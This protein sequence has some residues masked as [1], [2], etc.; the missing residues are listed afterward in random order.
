MP[1][2]VLT[3]LVAASL[4]GAATCESPAE[5][6]AWAR[7][8]IYPGASDAQLK[9]VRTWVQAAV[10]S[11]DDNGDLWYLRS[12]LAKKLDGKVDTFAEE[13]L[14]DHPSELQANGWNPFDPAQAPAKPRTSPYV[15]NKWA[16]VVG[17][18]KFQDNSVPTLSHSVNDAKR[19]AEA[20]SGP[21]GR[22]DPAHVKVLTDEAATKTNILLGL[23]EI[24]S[25][26]K[27]DDLVVVYLSSHGL[28][29]DDDPTG[30][31]FVVTY[32]T[33]VAN[34]ATRYATSL[35]MVELSEF[36]RRLRAQ[37]FVLILDTC[38]GGGAVGPDKAKRIVPLD[39]SSRIDQF[40]G[41]LHAMKSGSGRAILAASRSSEASYESSRGNGYF[42]WF[43][44]DALAQHDGL[45][46]L[47]TVYEATRVKVSDAV[48]QEL[49]HNQNPVM[50]FT[51]SG[52]G[53]VLGVPPTRN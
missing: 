33:N 16:L 28:P 18:Q 17:I 8:R 39:A 22:F 40:T 25:Q 47:K 10:H 6:L 50:D 51:E 26:A 3:L 4:G 45:D 5:R 1:R 48:K 35:P 30:V 20:L 24:R 21:Q 49:G 52:D 38:F 42:T 36:S 29:G 2:L 32:D 53:I 19:V 44:L 37:R 43:L 13:Q 14:K 46:D 7:E 31:S 23:G 9:R 41:S 15:R 12:L 34:G 27:E 11:C